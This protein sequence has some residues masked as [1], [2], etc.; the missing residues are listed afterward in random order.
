MNNK[1]IHEA[2]FSNVCICNL[3]T[4]MTKLCQLKVIYYIFLTFYKI[5]S[6]E[7]A[8]FFQ[9][10]EANKKYGKDKK[11]REIGKEYIDKKEEQK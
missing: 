5:F 8:T 10:S 1:I 4:D 6:V 7:V 11:K 2:L 9:K 3:A